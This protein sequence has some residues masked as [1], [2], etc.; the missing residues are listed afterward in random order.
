MNYSYGLASLEIQEE[1]LV[2]K[3]LFKTYI[4]PRQKITGVSLYKGLIST[5]YKICHSDEDIQVYNAEALPPLIVLWTR[6]L[7]E[8]A[9][10]LKAAKYPVV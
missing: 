7:A 9:E 1:Q 3:T 10:A 8:V 4:I 2:V 6:R 5:G